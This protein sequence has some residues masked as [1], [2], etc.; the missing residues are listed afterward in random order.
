MAYQGHCVRKDIKLKTYYTWQ[1]KAFAAL[2]KQ[3]KLQMTEA[4]EPEAHFAELP[5]LGQVRDRALVASAYMGGSI[6]GCKWGVNPE[7][8]TALCRVLS[9]AE[10]LYRRSVGVGRK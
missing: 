8:V 1:K 5:L 4:R 2:I 6:P 10:W 9:H 3:Q 7:I